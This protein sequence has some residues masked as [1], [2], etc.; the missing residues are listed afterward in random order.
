[1]RLTI[2]HMGNCYIAAEALFNEMGHQVIVPP[3]P[4][5]KTLDLGTKYSP[6]TACLPLKI[7]VGN[8]LE[9]I[10]MGA[11]TIIMIGGRGPCRLGYY[12]AV[13]QEILRD[14]GISIDFIVLEHP[15][16]NYRTLQ[17]QLRLLIAKKGIK[18]LTYGVRLAWEKLVTIEILERTAHVVRPREIHRGDTSKLLKELFSQLRMTNTVKETKKM[19]Q[20]GC[21]RLKSLAAN[22]EIQPL[23]IGIVGEI[24]TIIEPFVNLDIEERLG[25][26][27]VEVTRTV[28][29]VDWLK[30]HL[31]LSSFGLYSNKHL[32]EKANGYLHSFV[33]GHGLESVARTVMLAEANYHGV[34]HILPFTCMPEIIA[35]SALPRVSSDYNIPVITL[36]VDEHT[37]EMGFQTRLEAFVELIARRLE[38]VKHA[39]KTG[40]SRC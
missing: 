5:K 34:I 16:D 38:A 12:A 14:L 2:P 32:L 21:S 25:H 37:G 10:E 22:K 15:R 29:L 27:N 23:K 40:V 20:L 35:Q 6:E 30:D 28:N 26:L 17:K 9:A 8:F 24:Y 7:N 13:E 18:G 11:E 33:G 4:S 1:M 3:L 36:V 19:R 39:D 31:V